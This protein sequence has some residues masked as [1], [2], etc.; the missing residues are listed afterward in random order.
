MHT[1]KSFDA[2]LCT[3]HSFVPASL[4]MVNKPVLFVF[5]IAENAELH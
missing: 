5:D 2:S 1:F 4:C 3:M